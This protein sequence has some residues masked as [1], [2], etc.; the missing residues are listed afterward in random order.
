MPKVPANVETPQN[1]VTSL[2]KWNSISFKHFC[3]AECTKV[4]VEEELVSW[5]D[6]YYSATLTRCNGT[7]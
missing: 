1:S 6:F 4:L 2:T 3:Q 5:N 7:C